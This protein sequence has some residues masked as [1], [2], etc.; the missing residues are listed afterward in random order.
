MTRFPSTTAFRWSFAIALWTATASLILFAFIFW[1]TT[2][3]ERRENDETIERQLAYIAADPTEIVPRIQDW[4]GGGIH[5]D[6][7]AGYFAP[8]GRHLAGNI[9]AIPS[10]LKRN[11]QVRDS[12][13]PVSVSHSEPRDDLL[14]AALQRADGHVVVV[15]LSDDDIERAKDAMIRT[16]GLALIPMILLSVIGGIVLSSRARRKLVATE[17]AVAAVMRGDLGQRLPAGA[18]RDEFDRLTANVNTML[19]RIEILVDEVRSVGDAIA[20]DLRTPLTRLRARLERSRDEATSVEEL[21]QAIDRGLEWLDQCLGLITA[22]LRIGEI[23]HGRRRAGFRDVS[24][25]DC[26][27]EA[28]EVY[29]P[30]AEAKRIRIDRAIDEGLP[31]IWGDRELLFEA[32]ANLI[33]NAVKFTPVGG[34]IHLSLR[35]YGDELEIGIDDNGAGIPLAERSHVFQRFYRAEPERHSRGNGLGLSLVAAVVALH[36]FTITLEDAVPTGCRFRIVCPLDGA[37]G[38]ARPRAGEPALV[39]AGVADQAEAPGS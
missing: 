23:E 30:L 34:R 20:H 35:R 39:S 33:D 16:L 6:R 10:G 11:G 27:T 22:I 36:D 18:G 37:T 5:A 38:T 17:G 7:F 32:L 15:A 8:D 28:A 21:R 24:L 12:T 26:L 14:C 29:D 2:S 9:T 4:L 19:D 25:A 31:P 13:G 3:L 1:Q